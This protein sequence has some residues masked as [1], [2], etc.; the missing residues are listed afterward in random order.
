MSDIKS[1][2]RER[3][4][5]KGMHRMIFGM[6]NGITKFKVCGK[7]RDDKWKKIYEELII[8][9]GIVRCSGCLADE[10]DYGAYEKIER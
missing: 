3:V 6:E 4:W 1:V 5:E 7:E 8:V 9:V 10:V 2:V